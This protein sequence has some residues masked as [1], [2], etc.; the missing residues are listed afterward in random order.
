MLT[1]TDCGRVA[2][3]QHRMRVQ[4][5]T[6]ANKV[7][8]AVFIRGFCMCYVFLPREFVQNFNKINE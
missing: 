1:L 8:A 6:D 5:T 3:D 7:E 2:G 4:M